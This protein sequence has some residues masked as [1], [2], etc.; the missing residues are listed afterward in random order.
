M[1]YEHKYNFT[2]FHL[3]FIL[4]DNRTPDETWFKMNN[5]GYV[6]QLEEIAERKSIKPIRLTPH[7]RKQFKFIKRQR[8]ETVHKQSNITEG[9]KFMFPNYKPSLVFDTKNQEDVQNKEEEKTPKRSVVLKINRLPK[10]ISNNSKKAQINAEDEGLTETQK[11]KFPSLNKTLKNKVLISLKTR[12]KNSHIESYESNAIEELR[13]RNHPMSIN[14]P[15]TFVTNMKETHQ[16][17][18]RKTDIKT[19]QSMKKKDLK[20]DIPEPHKEEELMMNHSELLKKLRTYIDK[21]SSKSTT[22]K[23]TTDVDIE[24]F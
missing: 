1:P 20:I 15:K 10:E 18:L 21:K 24:Y 5:A 11:F 14:Y 9:K 2:E 7:S 17:Y 19:T 4:N 6:L 16:F 8:P 12:N 3:G 22:K 23:K 13:S